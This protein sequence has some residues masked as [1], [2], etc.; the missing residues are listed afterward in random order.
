ML[1]CK[2]QEKNDYLSPKVEI[3]GFLTDVITT[4]GPQSGADGSGDGTDM[5]HSGWT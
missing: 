5:D 1:N 3:I 4:S 2:D